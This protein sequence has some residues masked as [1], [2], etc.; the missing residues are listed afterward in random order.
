MPK[1]FNLSK[2]G[3]RVQD[4]DTGHILDVQYNGNRYEGSVMIPELNIGFKLVP[5][6][7][8]ENPFQNDQCFE[9]QQNGVP[10]GQG[11]WFKIQPSD[12]FSSIMAEVERLAN[13]KSFSFFRKKAP[14]ESLGTIVPKVHSTGFVFGDASND[15]GEAVDTIMKSSN[16]MKMAYGYARRAAAAALY[17]QGIFDEQQFE[18]VVAMFKSLQLQTEHSVEFQDAAGAEAAS[19]LQSYHPSISRMFLGYLQK[20][21]TQY[22]IPPGQLNDSQL[23]ETVLDMVYGEQQASSDTAK[24]QNV[25]PRLVDYVDQQASTHLGPFAN[26]MEDVKSAATKT[27]VLRNP[28]LSAAAGYSMEIAVAGLWVAGGVHHKL[29]EDTLGAIFAYKADIGSDQALHERALEQS[30]E[31]VNLYVAGLTTQHYE[32]LVGMSRGLERFRKDGESVL[33]AG[34]VLRRAMLQKRGQIYFSIDRCP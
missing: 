2:K 26:M 20:I 14:I 23:F 18:H 22:E 7:S 19:F 30:I 12:P 25:E 9:G 11:W 13:K 29:I 15:L 8:G 33:G 1:N 4:Q 10:F 28:V 34:E 27:E 24:A 6:T 21:A 31:L 17:I 5:W 3:F 32:V 16:L